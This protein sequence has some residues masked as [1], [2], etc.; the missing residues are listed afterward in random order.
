[1]PFPTYTALEMCHLIQDSN[2]HQL[3]QMV[4]QVL[5]ERLC[6]T[7]SELATIGEAID[8]RIKMIL[9]ETELIQTPGK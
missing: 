1:M 9:M 7:Y 3:L 4:R 5:A 6:Y 8:L 2:S